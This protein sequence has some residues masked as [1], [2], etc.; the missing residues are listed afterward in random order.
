MPTETEQELD[1]AIKEQDLLV[2]YMEGFA[3][4]YRIHHN[5]QHELQKELFSV[6]AAANPLPFNLPAAAWARIERDIREE[7]A[8]VSQNMNWTRQQWIRYMWGIKPAKDKVGG[9]R[10]LLWCKSDY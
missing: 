3:K 5:N 2:M 6:Q 10:S 9:D 1:D 4:S 8:I 7:Q